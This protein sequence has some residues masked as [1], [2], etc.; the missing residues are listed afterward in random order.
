[1]SDSSRPH[2][3]QPT[4]LLRPWDFP[5]KSTAVGCHCLLWW[6]QAKEPKF[7]SVAAV[8]PG[9]A[10]GVLMEAMVKRVGVNRIEMK[11]SRETEIS[12]WAF[13]KMVVSLLPDLNRGAWQATGHGVTKSETRLSN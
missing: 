6:S 2:G 10:D 4:R 7:G 8:R 5:G 11:V 1:M 3:L 9:P 12:E 13:C